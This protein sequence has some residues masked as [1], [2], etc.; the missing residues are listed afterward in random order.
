[1][2]NSQ[3]HNNVGA[4][5]S[6]HCAFSA[7]HAPSSLRAD[8]RCEALSLGAALASA[9]VDFAGFMEGYT[10]FLGTPQQ[11]NLPVRSVVQVA[12]L[13]NPGWLVEIEVTAVRP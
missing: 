8:F 1:M 10:Q 2:R 9:Q 6:K 11:P 12:A 13:A 7:P 4:H 3:Y 5:G